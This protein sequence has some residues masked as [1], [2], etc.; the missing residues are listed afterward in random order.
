MRAIHLGQ[1]LT[2]HV[3]QMDLRYWLL[4]AWQF[5]QR[6]GSE[7]EICET[8]NCNSNLVLKFNHL[9]SRKGEVFC[10]TYLSGTTIF[11]HVKSHTRY[12]RKLDIFSNFLTY[13][14]FFLV[15]SHT[16]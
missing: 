16:L 2:L 15:F 14:I 12:L 5:T 6:F 13:C 10:V 8:N 4:A 11:L 7:P 3:I 9:L 1:W